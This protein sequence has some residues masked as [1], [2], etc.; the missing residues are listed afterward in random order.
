ML[1]LG[2]MCFSTSSD[3]ADWTIQRRLL[4]GVLVCAVLL[5]VC[6][7]VLVST[8]WGHQL[9][10]DAYFGCGALSRKVIR[11]DSDV[12]DLVTKAALLFAVVVLLLIAAV[13]RCAFVGVVAVVGFGCAVIGE[14]FSK[15]RYPG[16]RWYPRTDCSREAS[17]LAPTQADTRLSAPPLP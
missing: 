6:Y 1:R 2:N 16:G 11:L 13:R 5:I 15:T 3:R 9:D 10:D 12:L 17:R 8:S 7:F 14:R 4:L